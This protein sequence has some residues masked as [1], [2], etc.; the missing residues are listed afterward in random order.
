VSRPFILLIMDESII[1][2]WSMPICI[3]SKNA[4]KIGVSGRHKNVQQLANE[5]LQKLDLLMRILINVISISRTLNL[6]S[7]IREQPKKSRET[8]LRNE[9]LIGSFDGVWLSTCRI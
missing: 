3:Y 9:P 1:V 4:V 6:V 7:M 8:S 5:Y 2:E